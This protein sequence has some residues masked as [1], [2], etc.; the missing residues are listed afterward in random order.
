VRRLDVIELSAG[1]ASYSAGL[2][3]THFDGVEWQSAGGAP[4][5]VNVG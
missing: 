3:V 4:T 5:A 2:K 1:A